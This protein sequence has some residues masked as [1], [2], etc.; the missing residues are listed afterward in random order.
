MK[1]RDV[2]SGEQI[3]AFKICFA[4]LGVMI[5]NL[6]IQPSMRNSSSLLFVIAK[7]SGL[8]MAGSRFSQAREASTLQP[9]LSF[10]LYVII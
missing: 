1:V 10:I 6:S 4:I 8:N 9:D 2:L 7:P 5:M 3:L